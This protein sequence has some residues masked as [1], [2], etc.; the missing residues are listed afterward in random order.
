MKKAYPG[1]FA[2]LLLM[3]VST[4]IFA[5]GNQENNG[6]ASNYP[7]RPIEIVVPFGAGGSSDLMSRQVA[8][9]M[10]NYVDV[11][12]NV[13]N[14]PGGGGID[15]MVY[16]KNMP[17]DGYTILQITPS[18]AIATALGRPNADLLNDFIPIA[19]FQQDIVCFGVA[20]DSPIQNLDEMIDYARNNPGKLKI[21]GT[22]PGG[23]DDFIINGFSEEAGIQLLYVPY[24]SAAQTKA[25]VLGGEIDLYQDKL[26]SFLSMVKSGDI[27]PLVVLHSERV[28]GF[29]ELTDIPCS[30]EKGINFTQGSWRGYAVRKGTPEEIQDFLSEMIR[31]VYESE[32][33]QTASKKSLSNIIPGF[34]DQDKYGEMWAS[35]TV[36][37]RKVLAR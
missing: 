19:N 29:Q 14:K 2:L 35:E 13:I 18:H 26:I 7:K 20:K 1:L 22:S 16:A 23:L 11:P 37:F 33:Y 5:E 4:N 17:N 27:R 15:G 28:K 8:Q 34:I 10:E 32:E 24:K 12:V 25:A 6:S 36:R 9:I 3:F 21:G 31:K 30:V